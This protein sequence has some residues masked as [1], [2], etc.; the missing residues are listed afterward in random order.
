MEKKEWGGKRKGAG[1]PKSSTK[2]MKTI[3]IEKEL[4]ERVEKIPGTFISKVEEG[5]ELLLFKKRK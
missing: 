5:L 4:L 2:I 1:R 3:K